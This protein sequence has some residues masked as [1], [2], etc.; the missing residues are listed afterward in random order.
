MWPFKKKTYPDLSEIPDGAVEKWSVK[1][2]LWNDVPVFIRINTSL[3]PFCGHPDLHHQIGIAVK[4]NDPGPN[5]LPTEQELEELNRVEEQIH[6]H[7]R[8]RSLAILAVVLTMPN[9][10]EFVLYTSV[11]EMIEAAFTEM[12]QKVTTHV[13]TL[14]IQPD[15]KWETYAQFRG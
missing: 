9:V 13:S 3:E 15:P 11:P 8:M 7:F 14:M 1:Q 10:R 4:L 6:E 5:G 12:Q 2:A